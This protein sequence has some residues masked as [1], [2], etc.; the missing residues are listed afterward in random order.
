M[1]C[2]CL[3]P[4]RGDNP[5][6]SSNGEGESNFPGS[7]RVAV[8]AGDD[9][10]VDKRLDEIGGIG[11]WLPFCDEPDA[12][13]SADPLVFTCSAETARGSSAE[14]V[15]ECTGVSMWIDGV[16]P[17]SLWGVIISGTKPFV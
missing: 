8:S 11:R 16:S 6:S 13:N 7:M 14:F 2:W 1:G 9:T 3:A 5:P 4:G 10:E 15:V 17:S 12:V